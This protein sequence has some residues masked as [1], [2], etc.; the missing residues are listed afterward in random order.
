LDSKP[1]KSTKFF[2]DFPDAWAGV[3]HLESVRMTTAIAANLNLKLWRID[4]VGAYL[5]S[6]TK[7]DI[8]MKQPEG[9]VES[10]FKDHVCKLVHMIYRTMQGA[11]NWYETLRNTR[12]WGIPRRV[13]IPVSDLR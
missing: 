2:L 12:S 11:H 5:N 9:F 3:T 10:G 1:T 13:L 8:Y 7:E 4:F 6:L